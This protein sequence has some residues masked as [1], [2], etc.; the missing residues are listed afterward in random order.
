MMRG[1]EQAQNQRQ[2]ADVNQYLISESQNF[3]K[4]W[5]MQLQLDDGPAVGDPG[6]VRGNAHPA[7][8]W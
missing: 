3:Q 1:E 5:I 6:C 8:V 4:L 7:K 2:K